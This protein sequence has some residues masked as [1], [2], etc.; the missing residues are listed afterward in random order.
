MGPWTLFSHLIH[1]CGK[2]SGRGRKGERKRKRKRKRKTGR[3]VETQRHRER[4]R[5]REAERRCGGTRL[6]TFSTCCSRVEFS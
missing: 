5:G 4:Q 2:R 6:T 1:C 3:E